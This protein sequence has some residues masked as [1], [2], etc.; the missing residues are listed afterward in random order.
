MECNNSYRIISERTYLQLLSCTSAIARH[1]D[2]TDGIEQGVAA[3]FRDVAEDA[4]NIDHDMKSGWCPAHLLPPKLPVGTIAIVSEM[5]STSA[6][7]ALTMA[8]AIKAYPG[9]VVVLPK[10]ESHGGYIV[11]SLVDAY[12]V[13]SQAEDYKDQWVLRRNSSSE[14]GGE[15]FWGYRIS[16]SELMERKKE[17]TIL[18]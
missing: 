14:S 1:L 3:E 16:Y 8:L 2:N 5:A 4:W 6:P 12:A 17:L 13:T 11:W 18:R 15:H 9:V 7:D 10:N